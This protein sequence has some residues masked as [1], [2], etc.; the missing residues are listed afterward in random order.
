MKTV[1]L[2]LLALSLVGA[3]YVPAS[4]AAGTAAPA[5][6]NK[7]GGAKT[8]LPNSLKQ[9]KKHDEQQKQN[10]TARLA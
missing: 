10:D 3:F 4:S 6:A 5:L 2:S 8:R 9:D 1:F 7:A